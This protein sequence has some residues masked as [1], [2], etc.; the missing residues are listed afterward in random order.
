MI[1]RK[2]IIG[3]ITSTE[4][5]KAIRKLIKIEYLESPA[6]HFLAGMCLDYFDKYNKAPKKEV[7]TLFYSAV[8]KRIIQKELAEEIEEDILPDLSTEFVDEGLDIEFLKKETVAYF[9]ERRVTILCNSLEVLID[10]GKIEDAENLILKYKHATP[11]EGCIY[12]NSLD[13]LKAVEEA[14]TKTYEP[15]IKYPGAIGAFWN[16]QMVRGGFVAFLAPEKRGKSAILMDA[17]FRGVRQQ[18]KVAFFQA[19]DMTESQFIRRGA[20]YVTKRT[21]REDKVGPRLVSVKDC[22]KNQLNICDNTV[23]ECSFGVFEDMGWDADGLRN[24]VT[25]EDVREAYRAA[26]DYR[27][28]HNCQAY[29]K[30]MYGCVWVEPD[31]LQEISVRKAQSLFNKQYIKPN[32][33]LRLSTHP[34][35]TLSVKTIRGILNNWQQMDGFVPD[36]LIID[37]ADLLVPAIQLE[38]RHQQNQIWKEL[39]GLNQELDCLLLTATQADANSYEVDT[40]RLKN[41]SEDKR[42]YA[43]VTAMYGLNQDKFGREK[44]LNLLRIN[45]LI[46]R[47]DFFDGQRVCYVVQDMSTYRPIVTSFL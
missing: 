31:I 18:K 13:I 2:I 6:A 28:C 17:A 8:K 37:Y 15:V 44:K 45:E 5:I 22:I 11:D 4:Y 3:L 29:K 34:N 30:N 39:R 10:K 1:E 41:F 26:E 25:M 46:L 23:R 38:F 9:S 24:N 12:F 43:H 19:G 35:S 47:E 7:E 42:K 40:L 36:I 21:D 33:Q 14:L 16:A 27:P 32:R 20:M